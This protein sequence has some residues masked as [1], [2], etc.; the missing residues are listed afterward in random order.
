MQLANQVARRPPVDGPSVVL[1]DGTAEF[2]VNGSWGDVKAEVKT[3]AGRIVD[4][5]FE[6]RGPRSLGSFIETSERG[7]YTLDVKS[8]N[9]GQGK[10]GTTTFAVNLSPEESDFTMLGED[11]LH[12]L[13]PS[14]ALTYVDASADAAGVRSLVTDEKSEV[15]RGWWFA[16]LLA[17]MVSEFFL[18]T[19][20]G[21]RKK[22]EEESLGT[23]RVDQVRAGSWVG[24]MAG[25][26]CKIA[27]PR[28]LP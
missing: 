27:A 9:A 15:G 20:G 11:K 16:L 7:Y 5:P 8:K 22:A 10:R 14:A 18:A 4:Q 12:D 23:E 1:A 3:P 2:A 17:V 13:L 19:W 26:R 21:R 25:A 24:G 6:R 28:R